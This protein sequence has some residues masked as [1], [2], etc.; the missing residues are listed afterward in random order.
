[1]ETYQPPGTYAPALGADEEIVAIE[2]AGGAGRDQALGGLTL[3]QL[4]INESPGS[5]PPKL[6]NFA[7][8]A[9]S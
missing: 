8:E 2:T 3:K 5:L 9:T 4:A 1:M 6:R 7:Q